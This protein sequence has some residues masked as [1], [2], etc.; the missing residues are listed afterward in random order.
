MSNFNNSITAALHMK[1][2]STTIFEKLFGVTFILDS[3]IS[4]FPLKMVAAET[5]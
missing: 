3:F 1:L 2:N 4:K 5:S